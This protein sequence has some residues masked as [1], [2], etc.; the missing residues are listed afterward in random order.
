MFVSSLA[1]A[2][3]AATWS[4]TEYTL[5]RFVGHGPRARQAQWESRLA[6]WRLRK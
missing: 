6:R 1:F 2:A 5:H 3:G 4:L